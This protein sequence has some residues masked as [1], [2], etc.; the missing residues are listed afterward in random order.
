MSH[1]PQTPAISAPSARSIDWY[2]FNLGVIAAFAEMVGVGA[3]QLALSHPLTPAEA[4]VLW[5]EAVVIAHRNGAQLFRENDLIVTDLF[6][7]EVAVGKHVLL[8]YSGSTLDSYLALKR[9]KAEMVA[10]GLYDGEARRAIAISFGRLLSY[11]NNKIAER[12]G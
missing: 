4:D 11:P 8:M 1:N 3:K 2:S 5:A 6:P 10:N 9:A 12:L 7:A